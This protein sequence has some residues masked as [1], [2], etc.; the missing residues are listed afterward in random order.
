VV[1]RRRDIALYFGVAACAT[2]L[3]TALLS[4]PGHFTSLP[5]TYSGD[6]IGASMGIKGIIDNGQPYTNSYLGAPGAAEFLDWPSADGLLT[7]E[8]WLISRFTSNYVAVLNLFA[9]LTYPLI[10]F[11]SAWA[12]R[13]LGLSRPSAFVFS[14]LYGSI[15]FHQSRLQL[16]LFLSA[17][18]I[19]PLAVALIATVVLAERDCDGVTAGDGSG[20]P[21]LLGVPAWGWVMSAAA[22]ACGIYY[23]FFTAVLTVSAAILA[24]LAARDYRRLIPAA[25]V[26][27]VIVGAIAVQFAPSYVYWRSAGPNNI[28]SVRQAGE[29][30]LFALRVTQLVFP[31]SNHRL[32]RFA[33]AKA[34]YYQGLT[35]INP[36]L[37]TIAYDSSL[38]IVGTAGFLLL[39]VWALVSPLRAPPK[40]PSGTPAKLTLLNLTAL[41]LATVGG[42]GSVLA[43]LGF[44]QIR[45]Y[46]RMTPFIAFVSLAAMAWAADTLL[47]QITQRLSAGRLWLRYGVPA[48]ILVAILAFGLWDQTSPADTPPYGTIAAQF[49]SDR[50]FVDSIESSLPSG[51]S[52]FQLPYVPF[53]ESAGVNGTGGYDQLRLYLHSRR[54]HWSAGAFMG[55]PSAAWQVQVASLPP[56]EMVA[57]VRA[58]E[59][60]G[61][62]IDRYGYADGGSALERALKAQPGFGAT[63]LSGDGRYAFY[64]FTGQTG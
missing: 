1:S 63:I 34:S 23:A 2:V 10:A 9:L 62:A 53:P 18:F 19:V 20:A 48:M 55:R 57:A 30:D 64:P 43:F 12:M 54:L 15:V 5:I 28:A 44:P 27:V 47:P 40:Q 45:A 31:R 61:I 51:A 16:H 39:I 38:G 26:V 52:I 11:A 56:A 7:L 46:D 3:A 17:Y 24:S 22:G 21:R 37:S 4:L 25:V 59:F 33:E 60:S 13:R 42:F 8:I 29:S 32:P 6:G 35:A 41:L 36:G 14:L 49:D 50:V 58:R